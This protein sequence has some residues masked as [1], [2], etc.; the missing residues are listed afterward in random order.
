[1]QGICGNESERVE[2]FAAKAHDANW[3]VRVW[4]LARVGLCAGL[5]TMD[6]SHFHKEVL[7]ERKVKLM[8]PRFIHL[9]AVEL[10]L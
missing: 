2:V 6:C 5:C 3:G 8:H 10:A 4:R 1:M 7:C 9:N